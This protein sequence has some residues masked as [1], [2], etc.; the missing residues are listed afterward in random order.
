MKADYAKRLATKRDTFVE[1]T[2]TKKAVFTTLI[3]CFGAHENEHYRAVVD[4]Q[5][6][7]EDFFTP[8]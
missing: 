5:V 7:A 8:I 3:S 1:S 6:T 2:S 4:N